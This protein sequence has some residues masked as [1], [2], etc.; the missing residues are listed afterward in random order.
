MNERHILEDCCDL[1]VLLTKE[2]GANEKGM[3]INSQGISKESKLASSSSKI[4]EQAIRKG[5]AASS[6]NIKEHTS[7][8]PKAARASRKPSILAWIG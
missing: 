3:L 8:I 1:F 5:G 2:E 6:K 7:S 4:K